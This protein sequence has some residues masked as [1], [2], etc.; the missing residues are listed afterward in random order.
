MARPKLNTCSR[1]QF[2][3]IQNHIAH[4][5]RVLSRLMVVQL[6]CVFTEGNN[7]LLIPR[8]FDGPVPKHVAVGLGGR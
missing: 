1:I 2:E 3:Q 7:E 8:V 5:R 4:E 6:V